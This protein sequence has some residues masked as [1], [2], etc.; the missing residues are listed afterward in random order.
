MRTALKA[1]AGVVARYTPAYTVVARMRPVYHFIA[2][3]L[4]L[5]TSIRTF[6]GRMDVYSSSNP[7]M[8]W[9]TGRIRATTVYAGVYRA[10]TPAGAFSAVLIRP[11]YQIDILGVVSV[12]DTLYTFYADGVGKVAEAEHRRISAMGLFSTDTKV[13]KVLV[14][15]TP[16][17]VPTSVEAP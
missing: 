5:Y 8:K 11:D 6:D 2:G 17:S 14:S 4:E 16:V 7:A 1:P 13:G 10:T 12:S 3:L 9:Y 15:F